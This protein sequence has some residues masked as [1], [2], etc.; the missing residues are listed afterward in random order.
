MNSVRLKKH[1]A[2]LHENVIKMRINPYQ[3]DDHPNTY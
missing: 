1:T 2:K 3:S